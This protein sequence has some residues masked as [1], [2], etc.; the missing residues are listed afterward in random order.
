MENGWELIDPDVVA[1]TPDDY[2]R[3]VR[4][5]WAEIGIAKSGY[6]SSRCGWF[7]DRSACYLASGRPVV[8]QDTGFSEV[9]PTGEG[10]FAFSEVDGAIR[11]IDEL[12]L[13]YGYHAR[14]ARA[15]ANDHLDSDRVLGQ[16]LTTVAAQ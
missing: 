4:G 14:A 2:R 11:A 12:R 15:F 7:S 9:L 16:L 8:A 10:L 1:G 6:V 5:S 13:N 3:F